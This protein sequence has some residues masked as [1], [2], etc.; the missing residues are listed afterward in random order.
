[1]LGLFLDNIMYIV[2]VLWFVQFHLVYLLCIFVFKVYPS[3]LFSCWPLLNSLYWCILVGG[4]TLLSKL[5][6][7]LRCK[8]LLLLLWHNWWEK[9]FKSLDLSISGRAL[10]SLSI[11]RGELKLVRCPLFFWL[12]ISSWHQRYT[13]SILTLK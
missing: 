11:K 12:L 4:L 5:T 9:M 2:C 8:Y 3:K 1:M 7:F 13:N 6:H 10:I